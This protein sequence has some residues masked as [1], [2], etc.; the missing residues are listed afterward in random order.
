MSGHEW[1]VLNVVVVARIDE[2]DMTDLLNQI[3]DRRDE[4]ALD[5]RTKVK[6]PWTASYEPVIVKNW[7][8]NGVLWV[9]KGGTTTTKRVHVSCGV[10]FRYWPDRQPHHGVA[11]KITKRL[12]WVGK[13]P[14]EAQLHVEPIKSPK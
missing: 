8:L 12:E 4:L 10:P 11:P 9:T 3:P 1:R 13:P 7:D 6:V 2:V 14:S 5:P